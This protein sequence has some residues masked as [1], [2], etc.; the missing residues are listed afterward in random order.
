VMGDVAVN[1]L[2]ATDSIIVGAGEVTDL[3]HG[4]F[5]FS[6]AL[7]GKWPHPYESHFY[8][9]FSAIWLV[10]ATFGDP[11][12]GLLSEAAPAEILR[13]AENHAAMGAFHRLYDPIKR[14]DLRAKLGEFLPF[15]AIPQIDIEN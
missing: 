1:R 15:D 7:E 14:D 4:C 10:S 13:C 6:A 11:G 8:T 12:F 3:Q 2:H 5:R 9:D